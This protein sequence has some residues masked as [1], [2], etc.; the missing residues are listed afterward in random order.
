MRTA[1]TKGRRASLPYPSLAALAVTRATL[2]R[3]VR[4]R[5]SFFFVLLL[6]VAIIL[7]IGATVTDFDRFRVGVVPAHSGANAAELATALQ[8]DSRLKGRL[9][10]DQRTARTALRRSEL[11]AVVLIPDG[12]DSAVRQGRTVTVPVLVEPRGSTGYAAASSV[13]AA[14][15]QHAGRLQAAR[16]AAVETGSDFDRRLETARAQEKATTPIGVKA[17]TAGGSSQFL[18][19]GYSYSAPTML[20]L[21]VFVNCL[22]F[23]SAI[24]RTRR[25]GVYTRALASPLGPRALVLGE[26]L[27]YATLAVVQSLLIV[28]I[29]ALFFDVSW[30]DPAAA[31]LLVALW[32]LVSTGAGVL[33]GSLF[34][35]PEQ[36]GALGTALGIGLG[37]LGGCTWPLAVVPDWLRTAGHAVPHAWAV[38]SW[39]VLLSRNGGLVDILGRLAV[40]AGFAIV[41][42]ALAGTV[43]RRRLTE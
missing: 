38:D 6:P 29:G 27:A 1:A 43:L 25:L 34:R 9:Y 3:M 35:T 32:A 30:G 21:F 4:D 22:A 33:S 10:D 20:V 28:G 42:L 41:L 40:L 16:F 18:P 7:I 14:V 5:T 12:L 8:H 2:T 13:S 11:D 39:T 37:M 17:E 26:T 31:V 24:V 36:A 23:G 19:L 15:S